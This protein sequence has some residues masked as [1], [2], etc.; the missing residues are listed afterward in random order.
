ML[1]APRKSRAG[2]PFRSWNRVEAPLVFNSPDASYEPSCSYTFSPITTAGQEQ[3]ALPERLR[4]LQEPRALQG[5]L[6]GPRAQRE[7]L[8]VQAQRE[9]LA[10]EEPAS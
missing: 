5:Q 8:G 4:A 1:T 2:L 7:Q 10:P 6:R 3:Q 9:V